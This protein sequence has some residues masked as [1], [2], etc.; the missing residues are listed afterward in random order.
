M[1]KVV[2]LYI[3]ARSLSHHPFGPP[4]TTASLHHRR[5]EQVKAPTVTLFQGIFR[6]IL[7]CLLGVCF[8]SNLFV[9]LILQA[10]PMM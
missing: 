4:E 2:F 3:P 6:K 9:Y 8:L 5:T 7:G 10:L 1:G